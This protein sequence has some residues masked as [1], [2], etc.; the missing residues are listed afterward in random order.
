M[1]EQRE[2]TQEEQTTF[3]KLQNEFPPE[4]YKE[5][6]FGS[7]PMTTIDAYHIIER[8][9]NV[10]GLCGEGWGFHDLRFEKHGNNVACIGA[11]WYKRSELAQ[12]GD[13]QRDQA[14]W[15]INAGVVHAVGD[16]VVLRDNVA[17]AYKKAQTNLL[18]KASSFIGVGLDVY[19]GKHQDDPYSDRAGAIP[20]QPP[21]PAAA[22]TPTPAAA[23]TPATMDSPPQEPQDSPP[24]ASGDKPPCPDCKVDTHVYEDKKT[25][26]KFFCW[27]TK[28][29][30]GLN[31]R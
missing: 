17:E 11:I 8:M 23:P 16:A 24:A 13:S 27:K 30:C 2:Q 21:V 12:E 31:F 26:G 4:A 20:P 5:L 25:P 14:H 1:E 6:K 9:T 29:G 10:F 15:P 22:P 18:S 7:Y 19:M 28:G 3:Q